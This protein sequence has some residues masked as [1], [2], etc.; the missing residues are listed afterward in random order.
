MTHI[1]VHPDSKSRFVRNLHGHVHA[2]TLKNKW[3]KNC[4]VEV[5]NYTP[6]AFEDI[7]KETQELIDNG[8][9]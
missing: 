5:N 3:Y 6:I 7:K 1:P 2:N 9:I 8:I 4:C